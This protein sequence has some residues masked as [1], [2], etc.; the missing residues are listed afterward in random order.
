MI[1]LP[2]R[3]PAELKKAADNAQAKREDRIETAAAINRSALD[4]LLKRPSGEEALNELLKKGLETVLPDRG[5]SP[6]RSGKRGGQER[7]Q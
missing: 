6:I 4:R 3:R 2:W 1:N 5:R 7:K